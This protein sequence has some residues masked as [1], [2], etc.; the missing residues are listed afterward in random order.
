MTDVTDKKHKLFRDTYFDANVGTEVASGY[1]GGEGDEVLGFCFQL[2]CA[3][4]LA[5]DV[6]R[7]SF[8]DV[9][10][11]VQGRSVA[12]DEVTFALCGGI[13]GQTCAVAFDDIVLVGFHANDFMAI[14]SRNLGVVTLEPD[15]RFYLTAIPTAL[16]E[17]E[18]A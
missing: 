18:P 17:R 1:T 5:V 11:G 14:I 3:I 10:T 6:E 4:F 16:D 7:L 2:A 8:I 13:E 12:E 9:D 15:D